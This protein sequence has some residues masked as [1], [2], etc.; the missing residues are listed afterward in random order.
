[1]SISRILSGSVRSFI[2]LRH[3]STDISQLFEESEQP[4]ERE[5]VYQDDV[6]EDSQ[7]S[8]YG[9]GY[10]QPQRRMNKGFFKSLIFQFIKGL[11]VLN[12]LAEL[13][14]ILSTKSR[15]GE[16]NLHHLIFT[17]MLIEN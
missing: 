1:M 13:L 8:K 9:R 5:T 15:K 10:P 11:I 3:A 4:K 16:V 14:V 7:A 6:Q 12:C 2:G 17:R